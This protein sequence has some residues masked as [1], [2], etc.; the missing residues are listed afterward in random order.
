MHDI[1]WIKNNPKKF[2]EIMVRRGL[3]P[4][5]EE[6]L[7]HDADKRHDI[8]H[9]QALQE[10][11]NALA[12]TIGSLKAQGRDA[13]AEIAASKQVK[14]E[15]AALKEAQQSEAGDE[16][17]QQLESLLLDLPNLL[18]ED[19]PEGESEADNVE[20]RSVGDVPHFAFTPLE[21]D[22]LGTALGLMDFTQTAKISGARFVTLKGDLAKLERALAQ[23]MLDIHTQEFGYEEL[24]VP[25]LVREA[26]MVGTSQLPKFAEEAFETK[27]GRWLI[28]TAEIAL[29]NQV[30]ETILDEKALPIRMTA[31]TPCFRSEAGAAGRDTRGMI[32]Q[33]QFQK[34]ELVSIVTPEQGLDELERQT[35]AAETVLQ[36][37]ELPYRVVLLCS[38]DTGFAA[39][40]TYDLE[41]WMP[42][43]AHYREISS[44]SYC[45]DFQARRMQA[46]YRKKGEEGVH[47]VHTLN[48]SGVAVGRALIA[49]MEN[50]QQEDGSIAIPHVLQPYMGGMMRI[51]ASVAQQV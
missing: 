6:I 40:K 7:R 42:G 13:E 10:R 5:A 17:H 48:G 21:H 19:V 44:S 26:A 28:S 12:K 47:F 11:S 36:R 45:G 30:R 4:I 16:V 37:L 2:D 3:A 9:M 33:H 39:Q 27:D 1:N 18:A 29:T 46:R 49:V 22:A 20:V 24:S 34:V 14:A 51:E 38:G 35:K 8:T 50:Y 31:Y 32:R 41:V 43:Q 15:I 23:Y 25:L